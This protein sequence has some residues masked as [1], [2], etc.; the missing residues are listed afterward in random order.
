M[1]WYSHLLLARA[2]TGDLP[3][4]VEE[5]EHAAEEGQQQ[6]T[7]DDDHDDHPAALH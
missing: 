1:V 7:Q 5:V 3:L 4:L 2:S 6:Q